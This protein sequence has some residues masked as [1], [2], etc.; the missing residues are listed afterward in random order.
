MNSMEDTYP[1]QE[2]SRRQEDIIIMISS[3]QSMQV[4]RYRT[5]TP[6]KHQV[7][8]SYY[9]PHHR[10]GQEENLTMSRYQQA[11]SASP[12]MDRDLSRKVGQEFRCSPH[13]TNAQLSRSTPGRK[14]PAGQYSPQLQSRTSYQKYQKSLSTIRAP[15]PTTLK[16]GNRRK[17]SH[18]A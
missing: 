11:L 5:Y 7:R 8:H 18:Y 12:S 15:S 1:R 13:S 3:S 14:T 16:A 9:P 2:K 17:Y 10:D 4:S 6:E